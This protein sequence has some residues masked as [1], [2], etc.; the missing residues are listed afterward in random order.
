MEPDRIH[1]RVMRKLADEL[2]K[3]LSIIYCQS[4]LTRKVPDDWKLANVTP[5]YKKGWKE[6][7]GTYR[8][9]SLSSAPSKIMGQIILSII[10]QHPQ[11][12]QGIRP[13]HHGV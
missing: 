4:W 6:D 2:A 3:P 11:D 13:S 7:P 10:T 8:P 5:V 12:S 1:P 9:V